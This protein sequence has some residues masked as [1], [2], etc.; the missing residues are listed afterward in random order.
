MVPGAGLKPGQMLLFTKNKE[1]VMA[2]FVF[3]AGV[4][5]V[6]IFGADLLNF[7]VKFAV[8]KYS[9]RQM[10][11]RMKE[12]MLAPQFKPDYSTI[13]PMGNEGGPVH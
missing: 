11:K 3:Y 8:M 2:N 4:I 12:L 6:G 10:E 5:A 1:C 9:V 13:F 7:V